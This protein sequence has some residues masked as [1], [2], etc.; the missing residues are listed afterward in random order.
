MKTE[1]RQ[2][3]RE[4]LDN[5]RLAIYA[6]GG[7]YLLYL[8]YEMFT[9]LSTAGEEAAVM[10]VFMCLFAAVGLFLIV[11]GITATVRRRKAKSTAPAEIPAAETNDNENW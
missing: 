2:M 3:S 11:L 4:K 6:L 10:A 9:K 7:V 1:K 5:G 8:A